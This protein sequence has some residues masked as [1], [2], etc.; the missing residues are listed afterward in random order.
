MV[1]LFKKI[2]PWLRIDKSTEE[3]LI[4]N[5]Q[6]AFGV[7]RHMWYS[8][9]NRLKY[10]GG[11]WALLFVMAPWLITWQSRCGH[12]VFCLSACVLSLCLPQLMSFSLNNPLIHILEFCTSTLETFLSPLPHSAHGH[13]TLV[14][15]CD[16]LPHREYWNINFQAL[17]SYTQG[18]GSLDWSAF[19][20]ECQNV[21]TSFWIK[22]V[23][24]NFL[25][26]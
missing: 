2:N 15:Q 26:T 6:S 11:K 12:T 13:T 22:T 16:Q 9:V 1:S 4:S 8:I 18:S 17:W 5:A 23:L 3:R 10:A 20:P 21:Q 24:S 7:T 25:T 14:S 19:C